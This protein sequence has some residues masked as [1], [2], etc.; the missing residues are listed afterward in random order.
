VVY[1]YTGKP[2]VHIVNNTI[3]T[4]TYDNSMYITASL[5][6]A[7]PLPSNL[8]FDLNNVPLPIA[9]SISDG[10]QTFAGPN[11]NDLL[12]LSLGTDG[13]GNI[14]SWIVG[15]DR[16]HV[17]AIGDQF[18]NISTARGSYCDPINGCNSFDH[19]SAIMQVCVSFIGGLCGLD[20]YDQAYNESWVDLVL[21]TGTWTVR[22]ASTSQIPEPATSHIML[23]ALIAFAWMR[24]AR[25]KAPHRVRTSAQ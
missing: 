23:G 4:G 8:S 24:H 5:T 9:Y 6:F 16:G 7:N 1:E 22:E 15:L 20:T 13:T 19:E 18:T 10:R 11:V 14:S 21:S 2:F 25:R 12:Y 17:A 3:P